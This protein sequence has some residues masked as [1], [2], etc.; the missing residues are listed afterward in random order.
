MN[1]SKKMEIFLANTNKLDRQRGLIV[2]PATNKKINRSK[3]AQSHQ[4]ILYVKS[5][6][7]NSNNT[8]N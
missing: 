2:L 3:L 8:V 6:T 1:Y 7:E 5:N 4:F